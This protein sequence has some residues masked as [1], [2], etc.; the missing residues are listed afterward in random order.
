MDSA[1]A[2]SS[3]PS[4]IPEPQLN[5]HYS[6]PG[7]CL[8]H[9]DTV[10]E[11]RRDK[12]NLVFCHGV[13][14]VK[15]SPEVVVKIGP[16]INFI[17]AKN[18]TYVAENTGVPVPKVFACYTYGPIDRD[19]DDYRG[20]Y[21]T[22]IFM[23][24]ITGETL[25]V[26]WD[27]LDVSAKCQITRQLT[28]YIQEIRNLESAG[29]IGSLE[30]GHVTDHSLSTSDDKGPFNSERD[31]NTALV[32]VYQKNAPKRHI[33][34]FFNGMLPESHRILFAHGDFRP[35]NIMV[36]DGNVTAIIDWELSGWYPEYWDFAK[37][38][39]IWFYQNDWTDYVVQIL[40]PYHAE[41]LMHS[42]LME[43]LLL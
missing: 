16:H 13:A 4:S 37:A 14:I 18:M 40:Q 38:L 43:K 8:P 24:Y 17:E 23:T 41:F 6:A 2:L 34:A 36:K 35:Q 12:S 25:Q 39:L 19:P 11:F 33:K 9:P 7:F 20:V 3:P 31:F 28:T 10:S 1:T 21:D 26:A 29:Y 15:I 22:Y 32:E 42:F 5:V 30:H 27:G